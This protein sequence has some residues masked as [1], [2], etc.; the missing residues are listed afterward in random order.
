MRVE[1]DGIIL[2][3]SAPVGGNRMVVIFTKKYGKISAGSKMAEGSRKSGL[4][5]SPF[6]QVNYRLYKNGDRF[7]ISSAD[8]I[9]SYYAIGE[10]V[11]KYMAGSYILEFT[12]RALTEG[13]KAPA[14]YDL[15]IDFFEELAIRKSKY[16]TL[17]LAYQV[18]VLRIMGVMP[19]LDSCA[20]CG[21]R[22]GM[23]A[24][25]IMDGGVICDECYLARQREGNSRLIY[26]IDFDIIN[27][28]KFFIKK[29]L[30]E[31]RTLALNSEMAVEIKEIVKEFISYHL[32]INN[33]KSE[34][35][36]LE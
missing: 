20:V 26:N 17:V 21:K 32:D 4:V 7:N 16:E 33:L 15:L 35:I 18:K 34:G 3:Q 22:D 14:M 25:S 23:A 9:K 5:L 11:D 27:I 30:S 19:S 28:L 1:T 6:T 12:D 36:K 29:P 2:R 8:V 24:F 31:F 10:D 13:E